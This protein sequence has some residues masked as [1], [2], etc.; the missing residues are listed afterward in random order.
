MSI[1]KDIND[2]VVSV[3]GKRISLSPDHDMFS[4]LG[5]NLPP[6]VAN[7]LSQMQ[8]STNTKSEK[9][10]TRQELAKNLPDEAVELM[11]K[12]QELNINKA[13]ISNTSPGLMVQVKQEISQNKSTEL[14]R[15]APEE[16]RLALQQK[17]IIEQTNNSTDLKTKM[18]IHE[19]GIFLGVIAGQ[20]TK[21][22][23]DTIMKAYT[24]FPAKNDDNELMFF[25]KDM[26]LT[27]FY[28]DDMI[29]RELQFSSPYKGSTGKGLNLGD[30]LEKAITIYGPPRM[31]SPKG[32]I[33]TKFGVFCQNNNVSSI[34]IMS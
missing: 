9:N 29:V 22:D 34:R 10:L 17:E 20:S 23:V 18:I 21:I 31:K 32:A 13:N 30:S 5:N 28:N 19:S 24:K 11:K 12:I 25:Y 1:D 2:L 6:D 16:I 4:Q 14:V 8:A 7:L 27:V 33:W 3:G 15:S 26:G